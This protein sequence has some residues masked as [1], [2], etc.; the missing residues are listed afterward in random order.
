M[1][2]KYLKQEIIKNKEYVLIFSKIDYFMSLKIYYII[3][4]LSKTTIVFE[5]TS[6]Y[7]KKKKKYDLENTKRNQTNLVHKF[8]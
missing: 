3:H 7:F 2:F 6:T 8:C 5:I 4:I 1:F